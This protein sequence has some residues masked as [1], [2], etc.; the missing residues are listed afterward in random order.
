VAWAIGVAAFAA[1]VRWAGAKWRLYQALDDW[2]FAVD[3][4][5]GRQ[6]ALERRLKVFSGRLRKCA[7]DPQIDEIVVV[8]HSFGATFAVEIVAQALE[9]FPDLGS[10]SS[11]VCILTVGATIP[12]CALHPAGK[13]IRTRINTVVTASRV[14]WAEVQSRDDA[15]SFYKFDPAW[16]KKIRQDRLEGKPVIRRVQIHDMLRPETFAK[17]RG[18]YLRLHYQSVMANDIK[19]PYDYFMAICGPVPFQQWTTAPRGF[20]DFVN[21]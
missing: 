4:L 3:Y 16:L 8:G 5:E 9:N 19:A 7:T 14:D 17:I 2:I 21:A 1:L 20:L 15:I 18:R 11:S 12:K 10:R 13:T 6:A